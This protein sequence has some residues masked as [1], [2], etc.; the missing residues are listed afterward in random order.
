MTTFAIYFDCNPCRVD[1][2]VC[3]Y[4]VPLRVVVS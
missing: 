2:A 1:Y 3:Q 4:W